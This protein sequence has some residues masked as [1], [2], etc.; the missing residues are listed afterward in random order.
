[1]SKNDI[2]FGLG[3]ISLVLG[4]VSIS[5]H[6]WSGKKQKQGNFES[7][8]G[9]WK[10]CI[11]ANMKG[12]VNA[13]FQGC[14]HLPI[15]GVKKFPKNSLYAVRAFSII[16]V[17]L[18]LLALLCLVHMKGYSRCAMM[19]LLGGSLSL[20]ISSI[21]W[22]AEFRE[23]QFD[24]DRAELDLSWSW[25]LNLASSLVGLLSVGVMYYMKRK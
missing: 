7:N 20:L 11:D 6:H 4:V 10:L 3:L 9:L 15:D 16:G 18:V 22:G 25:G 14:V 19:M 5:T 1:M 13:D 12:K 8:M 21:V 17:V 24:N 23:V 2:V